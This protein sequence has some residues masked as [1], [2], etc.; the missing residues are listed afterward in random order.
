MP[1][2]YDSVSGGMLKEHLCVRENVGLFDVSHMGEFFISGPQAA[3]FLDFV[4]TRPMSSL[5][6]GRARY[7]LLLNEDG[8]ILDDIIVYRLKSELFM[9]VVN[10]SNIDKDFAHLESIMG[11]YQCE[12]HNRS[13]EYALIAVQGPKAFELYSQLG[14]QGRVEDLPYYGF[15]EPS[16]GYLVAR[17]GYTGEDGY[18]IFLSH[19]AA[20][21]IWEKAVESGAKPIGLGARDTLRMEV[22]FPLYG[23]ELSEELYPHETLASFAVSSKPEATFLGHQFRSRP[24]RYFAAGILG[25]SPRPLREG[26]KLIC[27]DREIGRLTSGSMSP[28]LRRGMGLALIEKSFESQTGSQEAEIFLESNGKRRKAQFQILP[29]V[30]TARVKRRL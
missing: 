6:E 26:E 19:T 30:E 3:E 9:M 1:I 27:G 16:Q 14:L 11:G 15:F 20:A 4:C 12:I 18:E 29:F 24:A 28:L 13:L 8:F 22:G 17:T 25:D 5:K 10:A 21:E 2:S 23:H 7:A